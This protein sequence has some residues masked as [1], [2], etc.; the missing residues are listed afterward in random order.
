MKRLFG[1]D[2]V[3]ALAII[4]V[5]LSHSRNLLISF[6]PGLDFLKAG[7]F[8]GVELFFVLSGFLIGGILI[9]DIQAGFDFG[10][11]KNFWKR[12]W[13]RTLPNYYLFL[14]INFLA[15][16]FFTRQLFVDARYF[17]FI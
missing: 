9:K 12:R 6:Y 2:L 13:L 7:G 1:L 17:A 8:F 3:R 10:I 4:L 11:L 16:S 14:I 15:V 5:L